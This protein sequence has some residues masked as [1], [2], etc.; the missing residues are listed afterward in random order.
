MKV[1]LK[2]KEFRYGRIHGSANA[3]PK[4]NNITKE[5]VRTTT[6]ELWNLIKNI[7]K[8]KKWLLIKNCKTT[9]KNCGRLWH[10]GLGLLPSSI[11]A[12][13]PW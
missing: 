8:M 5:T 7:K 1:S 10:S 2:G 11:P 9:G 3:L 12:G 6:G 4:D 13:L